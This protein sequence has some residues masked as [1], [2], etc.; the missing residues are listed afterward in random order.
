MERASISCGVAEQSNEG[1]G[2][3]RNNGNERP[4]AEPLIAALENCG[5]IAT[6]VANFCCVI[7]DG[8][9]YGK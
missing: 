5:A 6:S 8:S 3:K 4:P 1:I 9:D 7:F 2:I